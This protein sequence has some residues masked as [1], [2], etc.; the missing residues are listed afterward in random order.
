MSGSKFAVVMNVLAAI[1]IAAVLGACVITLYAM[2]G[3]G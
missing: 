2:T 1:A 3:M